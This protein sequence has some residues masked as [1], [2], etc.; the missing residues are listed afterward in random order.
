[1]H[2]SLPHRETS[3]HKVARAALECSGIRSNN[4]PDCEMDGRIL[5]ILGEL[6]EAR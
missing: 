6:T 2:H 4:E 5:T 3:Q 1:M